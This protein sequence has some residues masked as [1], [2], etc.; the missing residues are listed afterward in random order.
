MWPS[1][2]GETSLSDFTVADDVGKTRSGAI[3]NPY[4]ILTTA[5]ERFY[6]AEQLQ[7]A[8]DKTEDPT[9]RDEC[10]RFSEDE[11]D[12]ESDE[13]SE[14]LGYGTELVVG[15]SVAV[16]REPKVVVRKGTPSRID[17]ANTRLLKTHSET[18]RKNTNR[19]AKRLREREEHGYQ[20]SKAAKLMAEKGGQNPIRSFVDARSLPVTKGG[21]EGSRARK[22]KGTVMDKFKSLHPPLTKLLG[23]G[24]RRIDWDGM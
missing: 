1:S 7:K 12:S 24:M 17:R 4:D 18:T 11:L 19:A 3:F 6:L 21:Y 20:P 16:V 13:I 9:A 23:D 14:G 10:D 8:E 5:G 2:E 22:E 15:S